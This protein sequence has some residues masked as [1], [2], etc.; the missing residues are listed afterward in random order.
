M[1]HSFI[2]I[3]LLSLAVV[4]CG[5]SVT[6][7]GMRPAQVGLPG[8][9]T[10]H[11]ETFRGQYGFNLRECFLE[12]LAAS[13]RYLILDAEIDDAPETAWASI[14]GSARDDVDESRGIDVVYYDEISTRTV[15]TVDDEGYERTSTEEVRES[16][17]ANVPYLLRTMK[18]T[19][20]TAVVASGSSLDR[21]H[22]ERIRTDRFGGRE[23]FEK[24]SEYVNTALRIED[25]PSSRTGFGTMACDMGRELAARLVP[26]A[27]TLR[28]VLD[29]E[30]G[31]LVEQGVALAEDDA[32]SQAVNT[33]KRVLVVDPTN[34][35]AIY[36]LGVSHERNG[37]LDGFR[38]A[39][40]FYRQ[41]VALGGAELHVKGVK[42]ASRRMAEAK[43]LA[44][45]K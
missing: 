35:A 12:T 43:K 32:W 38:I 37:G 30:G 29:D 26:E 24:A 45:Q 14:R 23:T 27:Y 6:L 8:V 22:A 13:D 20:T 18:L 42:R 1:R 33:W 2:S 28:V 3:L 10:L 11:L 44:R 36:N 19:A 34:A 31:E 5:P 40:Q 17:T 9:R 21:G 15:R 41:A 4:G 25:A 16:R 7:S 39:L